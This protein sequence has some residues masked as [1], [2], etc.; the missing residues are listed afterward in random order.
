[1]LRVET[2]VSV[3]FEE[4][5]Y[6][7]W[8]EGR[9]DCVVVD[10]GMQPRK[11]VELVDTNGLSAAAVLLTHGHSDHI[12]GNAAMK[13]RWPEAPLIIGEG[14]AYKLT[15]PEANL[16]A[17]FGFPLVT[18]PADQTVAEGDQL[19]LAGMQ[20]QVLE[21]PGHSSGHVTFLTEQD[22]VKHVIS[23]DVLFRNGIGRTDFFDGD[24]EQL[25]DAIHGKLFPLPDDSVVYPG[26]GPTTTIAHE[27]EHNPFVGAAANQT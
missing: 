12:F 24:F 13:E 16:S 23:G 4:N 21:T 22:G 1:M 14:D 15:D 26:H 9:K 7:F 6:V 27:R 20:F 11:I 2:I 3:P 18:P 19:D 17:G 10:P 8:I 5:T 25:C